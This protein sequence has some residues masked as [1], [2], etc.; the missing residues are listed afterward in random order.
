MAINGALIRPSVKAQ[1][2][3]MRDILDMAFNHFYYVYLPS[4]H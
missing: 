2:N 1:T 3:P 4:T